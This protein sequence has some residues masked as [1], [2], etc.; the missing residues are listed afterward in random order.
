MGAMMTRQRARGRSRQS[1]DVI[2]G[3][4]PPVAPVRFHD[5]GIELA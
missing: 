3:A 1:S 2:T 4:E 5:A